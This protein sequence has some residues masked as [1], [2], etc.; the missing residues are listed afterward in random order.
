MPNACGYKLR[1]VRHL[2]SAGQTDRLGKT[3][4]RMSKRIYPTNFFIGLDDRLIKAVGL[5]SSVDLT[6][7]SAI[8]CLSLEDNSVPDGVSYKE[9]K[10]SIQCS[11]ENLSRSLKGLEGNGLVTRRQDRNDRRVVRYQMTSSAWKLIATADNYL[12]QEVI[13]FVIDGVIPE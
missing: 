6:V 9:I 5:V 7:L 11:H 10:L 1:K 2:F 12:A 8:R 3:G 4:L 13:R